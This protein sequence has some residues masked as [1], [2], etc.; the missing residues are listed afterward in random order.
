MFLRTYAHILALCAQYTEITS[1]AVPC[2]QVLKSEH[3]VYQVSV[4]NEKRRKSF[5]RWTVLKRFSDVCA[6]DAALRTA[7]AAQPSA[8]QLL[9]ALPPKYSKFVFNHLDEQFIEHRRILLEAYLQKL[10]ACTATQ[11]ALKKLASAKS[12]HEFFGV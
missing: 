2:A 8:L 10:V 11:P 1:V 7:L 12:W 3:V 4:T 5:Q 9:P 6:F